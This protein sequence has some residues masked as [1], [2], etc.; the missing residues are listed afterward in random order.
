MTNNPHFPMRLD[1]AESIA[2]QL[3][4]SSPPPSALRA[5]FDDTRSRLNLTS[6]RSDTLDVEPSQWGAVVSRCSEISKSH[7]SLSV[8]VKD[9]IAVEGMTMTAGS[10]TFRHLSDTDAPVVKELRRSG[11]HIHGTANM[12]SFAYGVTGRQSELGAVRNP[13][14]SAHIPGGSSSGCA[15]ATAA[16]VVD[17]GL[18]TDTGGSTRIPAAC[19]GITGYKPTSGLLSSEG[20]LPLAPSFDTV[21]FC[22]RTVR[23]LLTVL[24]PLNM[25]DI[26]LELPSK[27]HQPSYAISGYKLGI[28]RSCAQQVHTAF[29]DIEQT[30]AGVDVSTHE[31]SLIPPSLSIP[32]IL[33]AYSVVVAKE[34]IG[35]LTGENRHGTLWG[36]FRN[37]LD[38]AREHGLESSVFDETFQ[39]TVGLI[40]A[41]DGSPVA[42]ARSVIETFDAHVTRVL[43]G[44]DVIALPTLGCGVPRLDSEVDIRALLRYTIVANLTG[45]PAISI[46]TRDSGPIP[47]S[48]QLIAPH[49]DDASLLRF[50]AELS[51]E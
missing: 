29:P 38:S 43:N 6:N 37:A 20:V 5:A 30:L 25:V 2:T 7:E 15:A 18:T 35:V 36:S 32:Q 33:T 11:L 26:D 46:P 23:D 12:D 48:L 22:T 51:I 13:V 50:A 27:S 3:Q 1:F 49:G 17:A 24:R 19:C 31:V 41:M 40:T 4:L 39:T 16:G 8:L 34:F 45:T 47:M 28:P 44:V 10:R 14:S 42:A 9:C 21:G